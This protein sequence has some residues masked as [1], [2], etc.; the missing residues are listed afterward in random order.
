MFVVKSTVRLSLAAKQW[1]LALRALSTRVGAVFMCTG[2]VL[3]ADRVKAGDNSAVTVTRQPEQSAWSSP[4]L[5]RSHEWPDV[6]RPPRL[7]SADNTGLHE[8][9]T[10]DE[11]PLRLF[12]EVLLGGTTGAA[13]ALLLGAV[14][15]GLCHTTGLGRSDEDVCVVPMLMFASGGALAAIP[16]GVYLG[17]EVAGGDGS[18]AL[19]LGTGWVLGGVSMALVRETDSPAVLG[20]S[21]AAVM[22]ASI[23][24][25]EVTSNKKIT[26]ARERKR[27][28]LRVAPVADVRHLGVL[29]FGTL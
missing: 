15:A 3:A 21:V 5:T 20:G 18:L 27:L 25:Y 23:L 8:H 1:P 26:D 9:F 6:E 28:S 7:E 13:G 16:V 22:V 11:R 24:V 19:T 4:S 2:L 10:T 17:G 12:V 29:V 14:G